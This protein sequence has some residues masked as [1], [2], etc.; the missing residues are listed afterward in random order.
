MAVQQHIST[1][2]AAKQFGD[3]HTKLQQEQAQAIQMAKNAADA[4]AAAASKTAFVAFAAM[5][6]WA[7]AAAI[8][9]ALAVQRRMQV[10]YRSVR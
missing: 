1:D 9:G 5:L 10:T 2:Q 3:L 8:G 7:I 4:T 6:I